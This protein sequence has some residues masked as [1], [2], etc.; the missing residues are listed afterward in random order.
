[1]G[2]DS[3]WASG[4]CAEAGRETTIAQVAAT[5]VGFSGVIGIFRR[6][7][8]PSESELETFELRDVVEISVSVVG[9]ALL[10]FVPTGFGVAEATSWRSCSAAYALGVIGGFVGAMLRIRRHLGP[11]V[12]KS[13]PLRTAFTLLI[14]A[15]IRGLLWLNAIGVS[16]GSAA[17]VYSVGRRGPRCPPKGAAIAVRTE[18]PTLHRPHEKEGYVELLLAP[19]T[20]PR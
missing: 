11:V 3:R 14:I 10:P 6:G 4:H 1:V 5:F 12:L 18:T 17:T 7:Q 8:S 20:S 16:F 9:F 19:N 13:D 2:A 15:A